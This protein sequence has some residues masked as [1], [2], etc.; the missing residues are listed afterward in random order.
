M[1]TYEI[2]EWLLLI[3][4]KLI[5]KLTK[6]LNRFDKPNQFNPFIRN[7]SNLPIRQSADGERKDADQ[8][9]ES[10]KLISAGR[11]AASHPQRPD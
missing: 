10:K 1:Q 7:Q 2:I 4:I 11:S 6:H 5:I 9:T 8:F 3:V